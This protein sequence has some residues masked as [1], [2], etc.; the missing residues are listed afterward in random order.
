MS[1]L[2]GQTVLIT[3][4][5]GGIGAACAEIMAA[6]KAR[7]ILCARRVS[8]LETLSEDLKKRFGIEVFVNPFDVRKYEEVKSRLEKLPKEWQ[9]VDV[10]INNAGLGRG[11]GKLYEGLPGD[12]DETIDTNLKGLLYVTKLVLPRMVQRKKGHIVNIASI[13]GIET[14]PNDAVYIA[15]KAAVRAL[16]G[17][18]KKDL[19]GTPIRVTAIS[20]GMVET[21]FPTV[22]HRGNRKLA[23]AAFR[24]YTPL[25][26]VDVAEAVLFAVTRPSH[27]NLSEIVM[28]SVDQAGPTMMNIRDS[29][30]STLQSDKDC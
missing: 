1:L 11:W 25:R 16:T 28:M 21:D 17:A 8:K 15:S 18:L 12:W 5:S 27:V 4:A 3:G 29:G 14:Y 22:R 26:A 30:S 10:L 23:E 6:N 20:P 19:L 2:L 24:G 13:S 9:H 7:L